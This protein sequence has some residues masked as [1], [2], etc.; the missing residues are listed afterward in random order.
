[1]QRKFAFVPGEYYHM[2]NRGVEKR[3]IFQEDTDWKRFQSLL[4]LCNGEKPLIYK[5]IQG[6]PLESDVGKRILSILA[7][8]LMPNHFHLIVREDQKGGAS[9][10][11]GRLLTAHSMYFNQKYER[12]GGLFCKPFRAR[13]V[14]NDDYFRWLFSYVHLNPLNLFEPSWK[15]RGLTDVAG[16]IAFIKRFRYSSYED[17]F[18]SGRKEGVILAKDVLPTGVSALESVEEMLMEFKRFQGESLEK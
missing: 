3:T 17:Y 13:H 18:H 1:M 10:F 12:S 5:D 9:R 16:A 7:Y 8:S 11:L 15:E 4:H 14:D 2:Y 6:S